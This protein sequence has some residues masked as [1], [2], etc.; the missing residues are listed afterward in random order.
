LLG[1]QKATAN[2]LEKF[3]DTLLSPFKNNGKLKL[4]VV[5]VIVPVILNAFNFWIIDNI[6]KFKPEH[7]R[8]GELVTSFYEMEEEKRT[9]TFNKSRG[10][11]VRN[12]II[13]DIQSN[14]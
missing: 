13:N 1:F 6:L 4:I 12:V 10:D 11:F 14:E 9:K 5:M 7:T 2:Y 8:E 3:G